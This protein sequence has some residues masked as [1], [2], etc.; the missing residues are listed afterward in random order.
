MP[1]M[2]QGLVSTIIPVYNRPGMLREA[3]ESVLAQ[4]YRPI[5]IIISDD[6]STDDTP[7]A[8]QELVQAHPEEIRY[9]RNENRGP[10]PA[11]EAGRQLARG[12][13]IQYLDS[14]DLLW[15][16]KFEAQVQVLRAHPE[17]GVAY[18]YSRSVV[19]RQE[20][21][22]VPC[23]WTGREMATLFPALLVD[24]WWCTHTPLY[25][26]TVC[27]EVGPWSA[28]RWGQ[29]WEYAARV[30]A[31]GSRLV[32][33]KQFVSDQRSHGGVRQTTPANE[34]VPDRIIAYKDLLAVVHDC[35]R[36]A[37]ITSA[38]PEM[39]HFSRTAF[40][41]ARWAGVVGLSDVAEQCFELAIQA[42]GPERSRGLD[43]RLYGALVRLVGWR[44]VSRLALLRDFLPRKVGKHTIPWSWSVSAAEAN[45]GK[46]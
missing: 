25:C 23:K 42:A 46:E 33:C 10:G 9:V 30:G 19:E 32:N 20:R 29:D 11:R 4:T 41:V 35:A 45:H 2:V 24:H 5:E 13:F 7:S 16:R 8:A 37:G 39:Q 36:R 26:R 43:F 34:V 12:E 3:V 28:L 38:A 27:D 6:G 22:N 44:T 1:E 40:M 14:D 31:L 15:P 17:C 18:G 21:E